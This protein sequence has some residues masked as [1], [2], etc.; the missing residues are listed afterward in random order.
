MG[1]D[2]LTDKIYKV[3]G[4]Y[5]RYKGNEVKIGVCESLYYVSYPKFKEAFEKG[6]LWPS[7]FSVAPAKC[8]EV[9]SGFLFRFPFP[10]EDKLAFG[11]IGSHG[12][13]RGMHI[14]IVSMGDLNL[15]GVIGKAQDKSFILNLVQQKFVLRAADS[16]PVMAAVFQDPQ[17]G[18]A[19]RIEDEHVIREIVG[20]IVRNHIL[21]EQDGT[22][23]QQYMGVATRILKG[24]GLNP[25]QVIMSHIEKIEKSARRLKRLENGLGI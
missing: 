23:K 4:E 2:W 17:S 14:K 15:L 5:V 10:D 13:E 20:Q 1:F 6:L 25:E 8:L 24:Y 16:L 12:I 9:N 18:I 21:K 22:L 19:F 7:D 3:M 11:D